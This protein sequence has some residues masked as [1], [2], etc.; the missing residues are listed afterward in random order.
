MLG[1]SGYV[2]D[3]TDCDDG[4]TTVNPGAAE[5]CDSIDNDCD[6]TVDAAT[7][8]TPD[9]AADTDT[10]GYGDASISTTACAVPSGYVADNTD[11]DDGATAVNPGAAEDCD[12]ID[13]DCD[14]T[15][16]EGDAVDALTWYADTDT[17]GYGDASSSTTAC[18]VPSGYVADDTDCDDGA[19]AVFP[20][21]TEVCDG[22]DNNC[23]GTVDEATLWGTSTQTATVMAMATP[24]APR[25]PVQH[26]RAMS[27]TVATVTLLRVRSTPAK[28]RSATASTTTATA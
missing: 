22:I 19:T 25:L 11:C 4:A 26:P 1:S 9:L 13:N 14:G 6:G 24:A 10:D 5:E 27:P 12:S 2:A 28:T 7:R 20:G 18:S 16:D 3:N 15:V 23:D 21:A 17:D 8:S